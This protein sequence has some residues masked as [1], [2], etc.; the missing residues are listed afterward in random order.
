MTNLTERMDT[1]SISQS[2]TPNKNKLEKVQTE[3]HYNLCRTTQKGI[4][5]KFLIGIIR[6]ALVITVMFYVI[7][8]RFKL[9]ELVFSAPRTL[10]CFKSSNERNSPNDQIHSVT[11]FKL[12][13]MSK[14]LG[15]H[16][17]IIDHHFSPH[18]NGRTMTISTVQ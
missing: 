11:Q 3:F 7:I 14:E 1:P 15:L 12:S 8:A 13:E 2:D 16:P 17:S 5:S 6:M 10:T 4:W 9:K 18:G